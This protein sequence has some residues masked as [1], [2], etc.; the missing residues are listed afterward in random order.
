M[1]IDWMGG[2]RFQRTL[3]LQAHAATEWCIKPG[4]VRLVVSKKPAL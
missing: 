2:G 1:E 4:H 3:Q